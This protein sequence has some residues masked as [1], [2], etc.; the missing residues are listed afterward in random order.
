M[1]SERKVLNLYNDLTN[2][3]KQMM[4]KNYM[5]STSLKDCGEQIIGPSFKGVYPC[6]VFDYTTLRPGQTL[7][8]NTQGPSQPGEHWVGVGCNSNN[9]IVCYDSFGRKGSGLLHIPGAIDSDLDVEQK[10]IEVNCGPRSLAWCIIFSIN[11][12]AAMLI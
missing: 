9:Q 11:Q 8:V 6:G 2:Q 10:Q 1:S 5:Y 12:P 3:T 4:G 7:I